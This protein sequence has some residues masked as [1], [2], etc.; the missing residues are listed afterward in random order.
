MT[1]QEYQ[2]THSKIIECFQWIEFDLKRIISRLGDESFCDNM[3]KVDKDCFG[4]LVSQIRNIEKRDN[5][6]YLSEDD[7]TSLEEVRLIRNYWCHQNYLDVYFDEEKE[8]GK[9]FVRYSKD[10]QKLTK[11]FNLANDLLQHIENI[12]F[13]IHPVCDGLSPKNIFNR[14]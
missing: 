10:S 12:C 13:K 6:A 5:I 1:E 11:D 8:T 2:I 14:T 9:L 4:K 7:Y 3:E